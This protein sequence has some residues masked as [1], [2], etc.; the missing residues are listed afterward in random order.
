MN[1]FIR[2]TTFLSI[3]FLMTVFNIVAQDIQEYRAEIGVQAGINLYAGDANTVSR[4]GI[5]LKSINNS[6]TD[7]GIFF[8]YKFNNRIALRLGY[9]H[10]GVVGDYQ[11]ANTPHGVYSITL[12]NSSIGAFDLWGEFN[13]FDYE[14]NKYN[15]YSKTYSPYLFAGIGYLNMPQATTE[16]TSSLTI[17]FGLGIKVILAPRWNLNLQWTNRLLFSDNLEGTPTYDNPLPHTNGNFM[18]HDLLTGLTIGVSFDFWAKECDCVNV[19]GATKYRSTQK[20][21]N[22]T[23]ARKK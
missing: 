11:Y 21:L 9:D 16:S 12:N 15:R 4:K 8:R 22:N 23:K 7:L 20:P 2:K 3:Y 5:F 6:Q 1:F 19:R 18:N 17:P 10:T 13:F 14:K